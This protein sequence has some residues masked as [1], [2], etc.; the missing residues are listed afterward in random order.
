MA[1]NP[2]AMI[3]NI[4]QFLEML[5]QVFGI[6]QAIIFIF[7]VPFFGGISI[8]GLIRYVSPPIRLLVII[9]S[10][11]ISLIGGLGLGGAFPIFRGEAFELF[12]VNMLV[13]GMM[14]A[15]LF[16]LGLYLFT[17]KPGLAGKAVADK[18]SQLENEIA[19][20]K[21][22]AKDKP[23][24]E[25]VSAMVKEPARLAG[26][27]LI[28]VIAAASILAFRG[29]PDMGMEFFDYFGLSEG[30]LKEL[31]GQ[32][33]TDMPPGCVNVLQLTQ[34]MQSG[35]AVAGQTV[36]NE[37]L[38]SEMKSHTSMAFCSLSL[39]DYGGMQYYFGILLP[40]AVTQEE[41]AAANTQEGMARLFSGG[42]QYCTGTSSQVCNCLDVAGM[43]GT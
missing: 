3:S 29:F 10:G 43:L 37:V 4:S 6:V 23:E 27:I 42:G 38:C 41:L 16:A 24:Q 9:V 11:I 17:R 8:K 2:T 19:K 25:A 31:S 28:L 22:M 13:W 21:S 15:C 26:M 36:T 35:Q 1:I 30:D 33:G 14:V 7:M 20:L 39:V 40:A 34:A 5:P 32:A 12:R 18:I